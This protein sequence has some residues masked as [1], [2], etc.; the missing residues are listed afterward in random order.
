L[1]WYLANTPDPKKRDGRQAVAFAQLAVKAA[2]TDGNY[3]KT[4]GTAYYR[5]ENWKEAITALE[6]SMELRKGGDGFEWFF[7]AMAHWQLGDKEKARKWFDQAV[8]WMDKN[9]PKN[10]ELGR[11]R[12]EAEGLLKAKE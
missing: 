6:R 1:A 8:Q 7:L 11:L 2:P 5:A 4:L 3:W 10:E 12:K 9:Q